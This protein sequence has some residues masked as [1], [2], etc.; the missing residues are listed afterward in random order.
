[1]KGDEGVEAAEDGADLALFV[2]MWNLDIN[3]CKLLA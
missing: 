2:Q 1:M 3:L